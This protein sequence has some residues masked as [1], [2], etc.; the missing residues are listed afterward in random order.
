MGIVNAFQNFLLDQGDWR[1]N[2]VGLDFSKLDE[3]EAVRLEM[4]FTEEEVRLTLK[5]MNGEKA[6]RP[7]GFNAAFWQF[8]WDSVKNY[9]MAVFKDFFE[10]GKLVKSLIS[11]F[12]VMILKKEG[13]VDFK[14]FRPI[15]LVGSF[16]KLIA[17][18]LLNRL[19]KVLNRLINK[20]QNAFVEGG[21]I[22]DAS[23]IANEVI[24]SMD[25]RKEKGILCKLYIEKAYD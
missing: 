23:L 5:E 12:I 1:A 8:S 22:M 15:S 9:V 7:N 18:V 25:K 2:L 4:P 24:E 21:Q 17:K 10:T 20:A 11:T 6:P 13:V 19:K 16:Y 14:D 3:M